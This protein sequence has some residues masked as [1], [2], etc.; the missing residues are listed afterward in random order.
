VAGR[1]VWWHASAPIF[2]RWSHADAG[3]TNAGCFRCGCVWLW[4]QHA[5]TNQQPLLTTPPTFTAQ[6]AQATPAPVAQEVPRVAP[7]GSW[8]NPAPLANV[9]RPTGPG[10]LQRE[11][12]E[13]RADRAGAISAGGMWRGRSGV[14]G[15]SELTDFSTV[16]E[17]RFPFAQ[18]SHFVLRLE[19]VF[20]SAGRVN[21]SDQNAAQL[22]GAN[23]MALVGGGTGT[24][25]EQQD[26]GVAFSVA[27]E[28]ARL[29]LDLGTTP[30]GFQVGNFLGG[31]SYNDS[32]GDVKLKLDV[33]R[34]PVTD[35][36]LSYAGTRDDVTGRTWGG[37]TATGGRVEIGVEQGAF[38]I[39]GYGGLHALQGR[40]VVNNS[41]FEVGGGAYYK[42]VQDTDM[43]F[44]TGVSVTALGYKRNLRYFT[45]GHG[46]YFSPQSYFSLALPLEL[47]GRYGRM[48]YKLDG[49]VG[50]QT[51]RENSAA[52]FPGDATLQSNWETVATANSVAAPTGVSYKAFYPSQSKSGLGFRLGG[53]AEYQFAPQWTVGGK[54]AIDNA[55]SYTQTSGIVYLKYS[56]DSIYSPLRIP[57]KTLKVGQ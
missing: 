37:V 8:D 27:Y 6:V 1:A 39:F 41:R 46:G 50:I 33:T 48:A 24:T 45:L 43:E 36:V 38:G 13:L 40:N 29:K 47:T 14:S 7:V 55:S 4:P 44:T 17:G 57:P 42:V 56:L 5:C 10:S 31:V 18:G 25:R 11:I 21:M 2:F 51:F 9:R 34:R 53:E 30:L 52:Y 16:I 15:T 3:G 12:D 23:A 26:S 28:T 49:S 32:L 22:F 19:P 35:S 20:I 54:V